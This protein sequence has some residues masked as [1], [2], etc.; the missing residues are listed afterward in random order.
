MEAVLIRPNVNT[1][2][3]KTYNIAKVV[4]L[5]NNNID[6]YEQ[7]IIAGENFKKCLG[8]SDKDVYSLLKR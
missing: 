6:S 8:L 1:S 5:K 7:M 2:T 3:K 4:K